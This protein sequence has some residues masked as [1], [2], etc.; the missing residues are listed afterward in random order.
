MMPAVQGQ[1][2]PSAFRTAL[3]C[4]VMVAAT[5]AVFFAVNGLG[6]GLVAPGPT[7][8]LPHGRPAVAGVDLLGPVLL[9]LVIVILTARIVGALFGWL[10]QP[11][12]IGEV[13]AGILLGPSLFGRVAPEASSYIFR[14]E[15][16]P[17]LGVLAQIGVILFIF[18]VGMELDTDLIRERSPTAA[19][20]SVASMT[21]AFALGAVLAL[22]LYPRLS[23]SDVPF[24]LFALFLGLAMSVTA[25]PVLVRILTD[26]GIQKTEVGALAIS[27]A[28]IDDVA[29]WCLL[30]F[31]SSVGG[32]RFA[33]AWS[34]VGLT[35]AYVV[36][37]ITVARPLVRSLVFRQERLGVSTQ[38]SLGLMVLAMLMSA[39]ATEWIGIHALF[40][41]FLLGAVIPHD[42]RLARELGR[43]LQDFVVVLF[44][45][46]F[47]AFTGLRTELHLV[48]G[49]EQWGLCLAIV[50]VACL[51][52]FG[53]TALASRM[54][55]FGWRESVA[56]GA[57]M[58]TRGLMEL[59][60]LNVGLDQGVI[61][62][63]LFSM[64]VVMAV[65]TTVAAGP[66]L[67]ALARGQP[68][69]T[70]ARQRASA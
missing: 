15:I 35:L 66:V 41:A 3:V 17:A 8:T 28:S 42:S 47:F 32:A 58:N 2:K 14:P 30:A 21:T 38:T 7:G 10:R 24:S 59:I 5:V 57:L 62:S 53:G 37:M 18:L 9:A 68:A 1:T 70:S 51:G 11:P 12:V 26:R 65:V 45:P 61:S 22:W 43:K 34:T 25:F 16:L 64:M 36:L 50:L 63:T 67:D 27:C 44:L 52:K 39:L 31:V 40:G 6:V 19:T 48:R 13:I 56:L 54:T 55:G 69:V 46:T 49:V 20:I 23:S 4:S 29:A 33:G 60:V